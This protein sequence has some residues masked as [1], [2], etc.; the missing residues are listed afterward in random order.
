MPEAEVL[1]P[2]MLL[3]L[4]ERRAVRDVWVEDGGVRTWLDLGKAVRVAQAACVA[5]GV[6]PGEIVLTPGEATFAALAWFFGAAMV[7]AVVA[8]LRAEREGE[9]ATWRGQAE[10]RWRVRDERLEPMAAGP[11]SPAAERLLAQ[12]RT[13]G[14]PGLILATGG[15]TGVPKLVLHDL[16]A[17]LATV[18]VKQSV[19][20][21]I[22]P[23]MRF[24]HIGGLNT[25]HF[26]GIKG[27]EKGA[28]AYN[29]PHRMVFCN[30]KQLMIGT[31][32][33]SLIS[34][35]DAWFDHK[36]RRNY[37]YSTGKI[38]TALLEE[39]MIHAAY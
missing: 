12:L 4:A 3:A 29:L 24:D 39:N 21:R 28:T 32:Q 35:L 2:E 5:A 38:G 23:L 11:E 15:T 30:P 37:I 33:D 13:A 22:M 14:R 25:L 16:T 8:P 27:Y 7:G 9:L 6:R 1:S 26:E 34:E 17:L 19:A 20:R 31:P 36:E 18:P 10:P